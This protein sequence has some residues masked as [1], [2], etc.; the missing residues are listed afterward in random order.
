LKNQIVKKER[1]KLLLK[2]GILFISRNSGVLLC[3]SYLIMLLC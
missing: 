2:F 3:S 1:K